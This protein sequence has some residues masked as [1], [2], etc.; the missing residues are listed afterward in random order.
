MPLVSPRA[1]GEYRLEGPAEQVLAAV[2]E[3]HKRGHLAAVTRPI[4]RRPGTVSTIVRIR[5][6]R[7]RWVK[8]LVIALIVA[9]VVLVLVAAGAA[10]AEW[11]ARHGAPLLGV[12]VLARGLWWLYRREEASS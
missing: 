9:A 1:P 2:V 3:A 4:L 5:R 6:P 12:T 8:P 7:P 11:A 10:A